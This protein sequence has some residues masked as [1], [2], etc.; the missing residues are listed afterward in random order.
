MARVLK[1][2]LQAYIDN[3]QQTTAGKTLFSPGGRNPDG[4]DDG[5]AFVHLLP[6]PMNRPTNGN[7]QRLLEENVLPQAGS[8]E[9]AQT[10]L[11]IQNPLPD[12]VPMVM[13]RTVV[14]AGKFLFRRAVELFESANEFFHEE[15][16]PFLQM[17]AT[18]FPALMVDGAGDDVMS[19][20]A[21]HFRMPDYENDEAMNGSAW[22]EGHGFVL[23]HFACGWIF[24][25]WYINGYIPI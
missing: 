4:G 5:V 18:I 20:E 9:H 12:E 24:V 17:I 19:T 11:D 22:L 16:N 14:D 8:E 1:A 25:G 23:N 21:W 13:R 6:Q 2:K 15:Q 3:A 10:Y 7:I